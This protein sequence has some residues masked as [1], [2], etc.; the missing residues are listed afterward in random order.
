M[1]PKSILTSSYDVEQSLENFSAKGRGSGSVEP[2]RTMSAKS[3]KSFSSPVPYIFRMLLAGYATLGLGKL[4][5]MWSTFR[6]FLIL[7]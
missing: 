7:V 2:S 1:S 4:E 3:D 6:M 5:N